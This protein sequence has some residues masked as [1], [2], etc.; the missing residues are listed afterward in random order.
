MLDGNWEWLGFI[1][2]CIGAGLVT[3]FGLA[4]LWLIAREKIDLT[5]LVSESD[6]TASMSRFQFLIFTF[7]IALAI[8]FL[9][10]EATKFPEIPGEILALLGISGGS[11]VVSKGIQKGIGTGGTTNGETPPTAGDDGPPPPGA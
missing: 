4:I 5:N 11:Y 2:A 9:T 10:A 3:L 1:V 8:I 6:G 7:V